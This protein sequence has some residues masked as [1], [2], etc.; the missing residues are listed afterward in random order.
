MVRRVGEGHDPMTVVDIFANVRGPMPRDP[1]PWPFAALDAARSATTLPS[2]TP[3]CSTSQTGRSDGT[4][5]LA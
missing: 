2:S 4:G 3:N 5:P 1:S